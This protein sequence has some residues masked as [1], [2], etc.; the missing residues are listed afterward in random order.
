MAKHYFQGVVMKILRE[1][2]L[3]VFSIALLSLT[4]PVFADGDPVPP[5]DSGPQNN[6]H[7][8][9]D[10]SPPGESGGKNNAE[11]SANSGNGNSGNGRGGNNTILIRLN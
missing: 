10:Q 9:G 3:V 6:G 5:A 1:I 8:N 2:P 11:N 7:G 4:T